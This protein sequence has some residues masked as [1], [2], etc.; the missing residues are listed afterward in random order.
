MMAPSF[1]FRNLVFQGGGV[2]SFVYHGALAVLEEQDI[3]PQI[4]RVAGTSAGAML[5]ALLSFRLSVAET[6]AIYGTL[7]LSRV[8]QMTSSDEMSLP[9]WLP[10]TELVK[11][12]LTRLS[13][14]SGS[15][16]RLVRKYGWYSSSYSYDWMQQVIAQYGGGN[17]LATFADFRA[18]GYR[19][20]YVVATNVSRRRVEIFSAEST[21][22]VAVAD[23]L[24]M[25]QSI[26]LYFEAVQFDGQR[27]GQG[28]YYADGGLVLNYPLEL[29]DRAEAVF[30]PRHLVAGI[31][32][33]TLGCRH[34]Q[35]ADIEKPGRPITNVLT[36][37][38]NLAELLVQAQAVAHEHNH[39]NRRRTI[40]I[41]NLGVA[42][43]DFSI[44]PQA[45]DP[46]YQRLCAEGRQT[47]EGF[48]VDWPG[49]PVVEPA[50]G[51]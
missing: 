7:D 33:E 43:T 51:N 20:V 4:Q 41:S 12:E 47:T 10:R 35:P 24:L 1:P 28:D 2:R 13:G 29:F 23:A 31:N 49:I 34:Y 25:S 8:P 16:S 27:I 46:M 26:P 22:D 19:A 38:E 14:A 18:R 48:L 32:W 36:Y 37:M 9:E 17:G 50:P 5:A 15:V 45:D 39:P 30:D 3:L 42:T 21:P 6:L 44:R 40:D 11:R